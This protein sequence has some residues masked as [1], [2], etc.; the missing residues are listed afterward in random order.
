[1]QQ[2][3]HKG[4]EKFLCLLVQQIQVKDWLFGQEKVKIKK[5][6]ADWN[7]QLALYFFIFEKYP[8]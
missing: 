5:Y 1:M 8:M 3:I 6:S 7:N 4:K 2:E